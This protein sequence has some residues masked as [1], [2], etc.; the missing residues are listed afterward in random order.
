MTFDVPEDALLLAI[1]PHLRAVA[2]T[3]LDTGASGSVGLSGLSLRAGRL[4][5]EVADLKVTVAPAVKPGAIRPPQ[6]GTGITQRK[7]G[8]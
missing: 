1:P 4:L 2:Q 5:V 6:G 3:L 7:S 8:R